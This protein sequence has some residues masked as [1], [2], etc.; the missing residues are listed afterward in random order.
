MY[1]NL[2]LLVVV[3]DINQIFVQFPPEP[4]LKIKHLVN[5][6]GKRYAL[7]DTKLLTPEYLKL[8]PLH[9]Y[10]ARGWISF[11]RVRNRIPLKMK[12]VGTPNLI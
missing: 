8:N 2:R 10:N 12:Q 5:K 7:S 6:I 9:S 11:Y 3:V 4:P 1:H